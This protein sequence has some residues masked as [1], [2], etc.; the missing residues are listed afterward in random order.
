M[1][2]EP[3]VAAVGEGHGRPVGVKLPLPAQAPA[4]LYWMSV[5]EPAGQ[6]L[7][8][9]AQVMSPRRKVLEL[10]PEPPAT[11]VATRLNWWV[12]VLRVPI[13]TSV[14]ELSTA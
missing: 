5:L 12:L 10:A 3:Q 7:A 14:S 6:L 9:A 2:L 8:G 4:L 1:P 13:S 11:S